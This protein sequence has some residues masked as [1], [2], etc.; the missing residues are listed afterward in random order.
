MDED[1]IDEEFTGEEIN[2][3]DAKN[4][5][6]RL[7]EH[8]YLL[9]RITLGSLFAVILSVLNFE[10]GIL[11][12]VKELIIRPKIVIEEYLKRD[13]KK[14]INPI[15]FLIFSTAI[16]TYINFTVINSN[17][18][19]SRIQIDAGKG[20]SEGYDMVDNEEFKLKKDSAFARGIDTVGFQLDSAVLLKKRMD[21]QKGEEIALKIKDLTLNNSDKFVFIL[22]FFFSIFTFLF[23]RKNGYN[24]TENLVINAYVSSVI[25][26]LSIILF[27]P[28]LFDFH[29]VFFILTANI[30]SFIYVIYFWVCVYNRKSVGGVFRSILTYITSYF[31][32]I[33]VLG[34]SALIYVLVFLKS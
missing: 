23:F 14:L 19:F 29:G 32:F 5:I 11:F 7:K 1:L 16:F 2:L 27:I 22:V 25:N 9:K 28:A 10:K 8:G 13:R 6:P 18:E 20:F 31:T 15:R 3:L 17:P 4:N 33:I 12:S 34:A 26:V 24:L 21:K 30:I